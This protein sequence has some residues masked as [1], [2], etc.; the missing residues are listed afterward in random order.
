MEVFY[1]VVRGRVYRGT[2]DEV[3]AFQKRTGLKVKA[4][5]YVPYAARITDE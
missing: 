5:G 2:V 4:C 1:V 3:E